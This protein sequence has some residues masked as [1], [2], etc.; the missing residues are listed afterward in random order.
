MPLKRGAVDELLPW[1]TRLG[2]KHQPGLVDITVRFL[3]AP[4]QA[5]DALSAEAVELRASMR[6]AAGA[7]P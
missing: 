7:S 4:T 5:S 6:L 3:K 1:S 2:I